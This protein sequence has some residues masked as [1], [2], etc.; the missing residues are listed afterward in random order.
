MLSNYA[1]V[2]YIIWWCFYHYATEND[3]GSC[4]HAKWFVKYTLNLPTE[5]A[6]YVEMFIWLLNIKHFDKIFQH[7]W[8]FFVL[9]S[10]I[11]SLAC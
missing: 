5:G 7:F 2:A 11:A 4:I 1:N 6:V 3:S 8:I 9:L 10:N